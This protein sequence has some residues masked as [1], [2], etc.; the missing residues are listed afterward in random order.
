MMQTQQVGQAITEG[1]GLAGDG[2]SE[3]NSALVRYKM[4][5][6][7]AGSRGHPEVALIQIGR[8]LMPESPVGDCRN[9]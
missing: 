3:S 5:R 4:R 8:C 9:Q 1:Q 2:G 7:P 6:L